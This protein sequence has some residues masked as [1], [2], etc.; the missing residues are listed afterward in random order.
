MLRRILL[1]LLLVKRNIQA[2]LRKLRGSP[3]AFLKRVRGVIHVG[4]STGQ[5]R[6]LYAKY[7]LNVV[8]IEPIPEVFARLQANLAGFPTQRA[9]QYLVADRDGELYPFH[10]A[11]N[12]G[13]SSSI[14]TFAE[15]KEIWPEITMVAKLTLPGITLS[16]LLQKEGIDPAQYDALVMD[17][18]GAELLVLQGAVDLLPHFKYIKAEAADFEVYEGCCLLADL[19]RFLKG[20]GFVRYRKVRFAL[21]DA[22]GDCYNVYY[23]N[24]FAW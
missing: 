1:P 6:D 4:G 11:S 14:Y 21:P 3:D 10:I 8:W 13:E 15:H 22:S 23:R 16:S 19:D 20:H 9:F 12:D 2:G 17:T 18:Q 7:N 5:E 24:K